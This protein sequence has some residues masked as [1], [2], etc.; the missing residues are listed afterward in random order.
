[1]TLSANLDRAEATL[2]ALMQSVV[3]PDV[4]CSLTRTCEESLISQE[5]GWRNGSL[6]IVMILTDAGFKTA[7]DGKVGSGYVSFLKTK[8]SY[9][10]THTHTLFNPYG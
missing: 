5:V 6:R 8:P 4:S 1:M 7:L 10:T 3:C 2:D 9:N